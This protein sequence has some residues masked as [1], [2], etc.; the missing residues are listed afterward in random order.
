MKYI[1]I[2]TILFSKLFAGFQSDLQT[3]HK[4]YENNNFNKACKFGTNKIVK[5]KKSEQFLSIYAFSC[6]KDDQIDKLARAS[7][8]LK[9]S[10]QARA[11]SVFFSTILLQKKL[12]LHAMIDGFKIKTLQLPSTEHILSKV[13]DL[14]MNENIDNYE[15]AHELLDSKNHNEKYKLFV[16]KENE[17]KK[18]VIEH[19]L[20]NNL[21]NTHQYW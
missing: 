8:L 12:L 6:L 1:F 16:K 5:Y 18:I 7:A 9:H 10:P 13:F 11:N 2:I 3:L 14:V 19:Y 15:T 17:N 4:M 20:N 21:I